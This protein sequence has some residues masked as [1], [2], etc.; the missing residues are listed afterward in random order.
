MT[1]VQVIANGEPIDLAD[2]ATVNDLL[3]RLGLGGKWV[4]VERNAVPVPRSTMDTTELADGDR[5]ELVKAVA[6]G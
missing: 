3:V 6:G 2:G 1:L 5:L 4:V